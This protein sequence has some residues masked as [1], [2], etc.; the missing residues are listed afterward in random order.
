M[1]K[2]PLEQPA[3]PRFIVAEVTTN[4]A[5]PGCSDGVHVHSLLSKRFE[6]V[7]NHNLERGYVLHSWKMTATLVAEGTPEVHLCETIVAVFT[8]IDVPNKSPRE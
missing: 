7:I 2:H 1:G 6:I 4:W 3:P 8:R 5:P